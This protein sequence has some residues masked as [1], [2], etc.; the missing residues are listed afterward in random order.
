MNERFRVIITRNPIEYLEKLANI[1][2]VLS[3]QR[4]DDYDFIIRQKDENEDGEESE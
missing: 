2:I 3:R 1:E 4:S